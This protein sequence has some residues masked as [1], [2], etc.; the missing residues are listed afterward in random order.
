M[1]FLNPKS[2]NTPIATGKFLTP[3]QAIATGALAEGHLH[4]VY[5]NGTE[6]WVN[7]ASAG[8]WTVTDPSGTTHELPVSGWLAIN[9]KNHFREESANLSGHRIDAVQAPEFEFL[10]GR[11]QWT[12]YGNLGATGSV[13]LRHTGDGLLELIDIYGNDRIAFRAAKA[14]SVM[15]YDPRRQEPGQSRIHLAT[16]RLV[17]VQT[18]RRRPALRVRRR[19]VDSSS[20]RPRVA[21]E[22][23]AVRAA[24][25]PRS[26]RAAPHPDTPAVAV[27][28][29]LRV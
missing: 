29:C 18:R 5:E 2:S 20:G 23:V 28:R 3:S 6:V 8:T 4:V 12:E 26:S 1:P 24:P 7:R 25:S 22:L 9:A 14:I 16:T 10:D 21:S 27:H 17:R 11:G 15:A 19:A 13:A